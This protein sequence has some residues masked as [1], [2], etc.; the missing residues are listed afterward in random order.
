L[1]NTPQDPNTIPTQFAFGIAASGLTILLTGVALFSVP[2]RMIPVWPWSI[3]PLTARILGG[4][5][6]L[7]GLVD[8]SMALDRRWGA[9][10]MILESQEGPIS[11]PG[12]AA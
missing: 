7:T 12:W 4:F 5:F 2:E 11:H 10:R 8:L 3:T 6:V 1:P 9:G